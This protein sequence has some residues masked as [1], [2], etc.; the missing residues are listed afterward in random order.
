LI[1][2]TLPNDGLEVRDLRVELARSSVDIVDEVSFNVAPGEIMGL[3]GESGCG[4][5]TVGLALLGYSK[6]GARIVGGVVRVGAQEILALS[7]RS[8]RDVRGRLVSYVPQDPS[9]ALNPAIRVYDQLEESLRVHGFGASAEERRARIAEMLQ[10]VLLPNEMSMLRR[11]PH[12]FSGGQLQR[13]ALAMAFAHRPRVIVLDE[14]TTGL[15]VTTQ[16]HVLE[17]VRVLCR[18][19]AVAAV[20]ITHDL[21][22][23]ANTATRLG[24]MYAGRLVEHGP[25]DQLFRAAAHPYTR[26]LLEAV[27]DI[28]GRYPLLGIP[29]RTA[30]PKH[31]PTGCSF[32]PRC[33]YAVEQCRQTF[34]PVEQMASAH[35]ARCFRAREVMTEAAR[36]RTA[37]VAQER[38]LVDGEPLLSMIDVRASY[39][40]H[41]VVH[42]ASLGVY[43]RRCLALV[44][45]S[46]SGKTTLARC[47]AGVHRDLEGEIRFAGQ[48]LA[49]VARD[50]PR[51][52]RQ[53]VQYIFQN[54]YGSLNP[55]K[56]VGQIVA[57]PLVLFFR[58]SRRDLHARVEAALEQVSLTA[59]HGERY[60]D[61]LSGGERQRVAIARALAAEPRLLICDEITSALDAPVQ[62]SIVELLRDLQRDMQLS[63]LFVTHN[64]ALVA[65]IADE[66]AVMCAGSIV[67]HGPVDDVLTA[68]KADYTR[69]LVADT[70]SVDGASRAAA[71]AASPGADG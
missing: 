26:R 4:K 58:P 34:P 2:T 36:E 60:P 46:G 67:E 27:P 41:E 50:R 29:G 57:D 38:G 12:Q 15:D 47:V 45:E 40:G 16:A 9:V 71:T 59:E 65:N 31:R 1:A 56:T 55:R 54:P 35:D 69:V 19:Y 64:L 33:E 13:I 68:P 20:Y 14:P 66:V 48:P 5:T 7:Q 63:M 37:S 44:G 10:E 6:R 22:V 30:M 42:G 61:E 23:V 21:A 51:E 53:H 43:P 17:T 25:R 62:A 70:P 24:V 32:A 11:Y 18:S 39:A 49:R 28:S 3:V 8:L 52:T